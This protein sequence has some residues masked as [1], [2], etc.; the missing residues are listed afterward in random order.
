MAIG[1]SAKQIRDPI[2]HTE[3]DIWQPGVGTSW[4]IELL[5]PLTDTSPDVSVYDI[6]LFTNTA[7]TIAQ[8]HALGRMVICY[9]SAGSY[10]D[11]RP[12]SGSFTPADYGNPLNGWP[13]EWWA[14]TRSTNVRNIMIARL[15]LAASKGCDGV[16]PDNIDGYENDNG[17]GLTEA[18]A[19]DYVTFLANA[20]HDR[21][22]SIGLKN[23]GAITSQVIDFMQWEI[24]EQ[25]LVFNE[26][27]TFRPFIDAGK[28]VFHIEYP[29]SAP[30]VDQATK[31]AICNDPSA[32]DFSTVLKNNNL[33]NWLLAC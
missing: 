27:E 22:M 2:S 12:D 30:N 26:C 14:D 25:C 16:D 33:D 11:F 7:D 23:G 28:P 20:A 9:F 5:N 1:V 15:D 21:G 29:A 24:N 3:R 6:D 18:D 4:Q 32:A 8:L 17:L 19:V 13:G 10:E 31:D